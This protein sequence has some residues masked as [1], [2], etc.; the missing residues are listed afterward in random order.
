MYPDFEFLKA[1]LV[2]NENEA[3]ENNKGGYSRSQCLRFR[4]HSAYAQK[5]SGVEIIGGRRCCCY[6]FNFFLDPLS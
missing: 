2:T 3:F 6:F 1:F 5:N 4:L